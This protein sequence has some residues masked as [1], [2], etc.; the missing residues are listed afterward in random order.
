M[1]PPTTNTANT[2][3]NIASKTT[4][5]HACIQHPTDRQN[6]T[7]HAALCLDG[8]LLHALLALLLALLF[9]ELALLVGA[10]AAELGV[11]LLLLELVGRQLALLSLLLLFDATDLG[12]L[13]VT[14]L[15]DAAQ[16]LGA[17]VRCRRKVVRQPQEVVEDGRR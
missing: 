1:Q 4:E 12:N 6:K 13:L 14:R 5:T 9:E 16:R 15:L 7:S 11:A 17:E 2:T 3:A 10:Q 8:T